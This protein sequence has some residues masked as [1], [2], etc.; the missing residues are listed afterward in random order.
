VVN[1]GN[2]L[3]LRIKNYCPR[4]TAD[5][6]ICQL[7]RRKKMTIFLG[8]LI[9]L[10]VAFLVFSMAV[11]EWTDKDPFEFMAAFGKKKNVL[12][13]QGS[14]LGDQKDSLGKSP[15]PEVTERITAKKANKNPKLAGTKKQVLKISGQPARRAG[16]KNKKPRSR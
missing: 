2:L 8:A 4:L 1:P 13:V 10:L 5:A 15:T 14:L 9:I 16:S 12:F 11:A 7:F 3:N 6:I